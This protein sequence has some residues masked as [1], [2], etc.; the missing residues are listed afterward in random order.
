M[1][2]EPSLDLNIIWTYDLGFG[3]NS[4]DGDQFVSIMRSYYI[5]IKNWVLAHPIVLGFNL[6]GLFMMGNMIGIGLFKELTFE[7]F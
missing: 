5:H 7:L 4:R 2:S 3:C 1:S 6:V